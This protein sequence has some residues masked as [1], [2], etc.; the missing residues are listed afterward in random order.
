MRMTQQSPRQGGDEAMRRDCR[1][2]A[3]RPFRP[4]LAAHPKLPDDTRLW[5]A[6]QEVCGGTSAGC[7]YDVDTIV[8]ALEAGKKTLRKE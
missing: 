1:L 6:L 4:D 3:E 5:A 8:E 2:L 7:V